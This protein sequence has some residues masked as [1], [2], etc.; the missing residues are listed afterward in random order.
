MVGENQKKLCEMLKKRLPWFEF[1]QQTYDSNGL[2]N[3]PSA[4]Y[5]GT[6]C[7]FVVDFIYNGRGLNTGIAD[8]FV[9]KYEYIE[10]PPDMYEYVDHSPRSVDYLAIVGL[11]ANDPDIENKMDMVASE[12]ERYTKFPFDTDHTGN[13]EY[14]LDFRR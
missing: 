7:V 9:D 4:F 1:P 8:Y 3:E 6:Y 5:E 11:K 14:E 2:R 10:C 13:Q 12:I